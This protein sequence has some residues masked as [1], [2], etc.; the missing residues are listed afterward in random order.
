MYRHGP[1]CLAG[2]VSKARVMWIWSDS[3]ATETDTVTLEPQD[4]ADPLSSRADIRMDLVQRVR[5]EIAEGVYD[6]PDKWDAA[7][8]ALL[9]RL[10]QAD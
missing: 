9:D 4:S 6:T 8:D 3:G 10:E 7:L 2:P 1:T 5:R